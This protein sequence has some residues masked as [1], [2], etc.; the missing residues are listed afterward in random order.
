MSY[1]E[2][3]NVEIEEIKLRGEARKVKP[4]APLGDRIRPGR[5]VAGPIDEV[6]TKVLD[7]QLTQG[8]MPV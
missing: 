5:N 1:V 6:L 2:Y 4:V 8:S 7:L 3:E